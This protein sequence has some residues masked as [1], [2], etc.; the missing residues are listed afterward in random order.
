MR[1]H[2]VIQRHGLPT[3]RVLWT[4]SS[5]SSAS[6]NANSAVSSFATV[7]SST[8]TSTRAPNVGF[9]AGAAAAA[10]G[11]GGLTIAQLLEDVNEVIPLETQV[12]EDISV[13]GGAGQ[14]GLE[15][16]AVEVM[17]FECLHFME[18]DG[19]LRDGDEVV[20]RALQ[21][22]DLMARR[23]TGRHQISID[24]K[25][26]IDGVPFGKPYIQKAVS[27]R[28]PV[29]IPPRK[30]RRLNFGGWR[31]DDALAEEFNDEEDDDENDPNWE[32][33]ADGT[34]K[35][36]AV[37]AGDED[38]DDDEYDY[39]SNSDVSVATP[40]EEA[41]DIAPK[42]RIEEQHR[43]KTTRSSPLTHSL[44]R[45]A[46][47]KSKRESQTD[48]RAAKRKLHGILHQKE[49]NTPTGS[50]K[51]SLSVSFE[52]QREVDSDGS[53]SS[54][55]ESESES[56][57]VAET[58]DSS[59]K[60]ET[61]SV[62]PSDTSSGEASPEEYSSSS[63]S[64]SVS[65]SKASKQKAAVSSAENTSQTTTAAPR[66]TVRPP[67]T[68]SRKTK[69]TNRRNKLR[70]K[71]EKLKELG[72]LH[73]DAKFDDLRK[74]CE[75]NPGPFPGTLGEGISGTHAKDDDEQ[76]EFE[77][78]RAQLLR[79]IAKGGID[80]SPQ[81]T[82]STTKLSPPESMSTTPINGAN[83]VPELGAESSKRQSTLDVPSSRRLVFGSL[84]LK[85][86]KNK[87]DEDALREKLVPQLSQPKS[88]STPVS[89]EEVHKPTEAEAGSIENWEDRLTLQATEC[90]YDDIKLS[91]PPFPFVQ[92][93]DKA[94]Q[95]A[96]RERKGNQQ[97]S[98]KKRKRKSRNHQEDYY[99]QE[100]W[101]G[102]VRFSN[103]HELDYGGD[104]VDE[105]GI[106]TKSL[107]GAARD[108][109]NF[110]MTDVE[111]KSPDKDAPTDDLPSLPDD[112]STLRD[113]RDEDMKP[114][115]IITF[116]QLDMSKA[117]N[118][119]PLVSEY[120]T[121]I[122][123]GV[124]D[125]TLMLRLA[126][127]HRE[128]PPEN[129]DDGDDEATRYTKFE[130]P[131]YDD[132]NGED[133]GF[134]EMQFGEFIEPKLL[135]AAPLD[136]AVDVVE[137]TQSHLPMEHPSPIP[138]V[139]AVSSPTRHEISEM[140]RDAGFRSGFDSDFPPPEEP[141]PIPKVSTINNNV[142]IE[143]AEANEVVSP[144]VK[145]PAFAG[146]TSSPPLDPLW[147]ANRDNSPLT[148]AAPVNGSPVTVPQKQLTTGVPNSV[149]WVEC[150]TSE[151]S[152]LKPSSDPQKSSALPDNQAQH[153]KF[154]DS[155]AS[156]SEPHTK[157]P[158]A[159]SQLGP[160]IE[161]VIEDDLETVTKPVDGGRTDACAQDS[162]QT[163]HA[164][165]DGHK[166]S[167]RSFEPDQTSMDQDDPQF[168]ILPSAVEE[169]QLAEH[170]PGSSENSV[171]TNPFYESDTGFTTMSPS[172]PRFVST[173]PPRTTTAAEQ[174]P[175]ASITR[176][177]K[178]R[179]ERN[180]LSSPR[181]LS[182][183]P[184]QQPRRYDNQMNL[185]ATPEADKQST[186]HS[187]YANKQKMPQNDGSSIVDLTISSDP[188]SPGNSDGDFAA[189][190]GLPRGPGWVKKRGV[191][192][193]RTRGVGSPSV[194]KR[195]RG[196]RKRSV[197]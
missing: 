100:G 167:P 9:G 181:Q 155:S 183:S 158:A 12:E 73:K 173:A 144:T 19:L 122:V 93:W 146:F 131:G 113:A 23:L 87:K 68:G 5:P 159:T 77:R 58:N 178:R 107:N 45:R 62:S 42:Q 80:V 53:T 179:S 104:G 171:I 40:S 123:E 174:S 106:S 18:V 69:N 30:K 140:I 20:I 16:Y 130:M 121:A 125:G 74:W 75:A 120:R 195:R 54:D 31:V 34:G 166:S 112:I 169:S 95:A 189:S 175:Q 79:D 136:S 89:A 148:T 168:Y 63:D 172:M 8:I 117:T 91:T 90:L 160:H 151:P 124:A 187:E 52:D 50:P 83:G 13:G 41:I 59:D 88:Q 192:G 186:Q 126:R 188:E 116:K 150:P 3:T 11:S 114:G 7:S 147:N 25:H 170:R 70:R 119:Q 127:R 29:T 103:E 71:L 78:K 2:L 32:E 194:E 164:P 118:W 182:S 115:A 128:Q 157:D 24:G 163:H 105:H 99:D 101:N 138:E 143:D 46:A 57:S 134:R 1:L 176:R 153:L 92:R 21:P 94:A 108:Q 161:A 177:R 38:E 152:F 180:I 36:L 55:S 110:D 17:G 81:H 149:A 37:I 98:G 48:P 56:V 72:I 15:D 47:G 67:G 26:L 165:S 33:G 109:P 51:R 135:S 27:S 96:I 44:N 137:K 190:Q 4:T 133:D 162:R 132:W 82:K 60:N 141:F 154:D 102:E 76:S 43:K 22:G 35:E 6:S 139:I 145:S 185:P 10:A 28:P 65:G 84:G 86:P 85:T 129:H 197:I 97:S 66:A 61:S 191:R 49:Q 196:L 64:S 111:V 184:P 142:A 14:W 193:T 39:Q 156:D